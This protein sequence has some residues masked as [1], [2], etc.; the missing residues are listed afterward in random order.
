MATRSFESRAVNLYPWP[1]GESAECDPWC[2]G[3]L[4][5]HYYVHFMQTGE[6]RM[7]DTSAAG[8]PANRGGNLE[9]AAIVTSANGKY[10]AFASNATNL[11]SSVDGVEGSQVYL[12]NLSN[13]KI[14][15]ISET[16]SGS[17]PPGV[18]GI[19][20]PLAISANGNIVLF[21]SDLP[22]DPTHPESFVFIRNRSAHTTAGLTVS[23]SLS[24]NPQQ[25][26]SDGKIYA[27]LEEPAHL[28]LAWELEHLVPQGATELPQV[29]S[30][31]LLS[32]DGSEIFIDSESDLAGDGLGA[33]I[34][35]FGRLAGT[36]SRRT[37]VSG[38]DLQAATR[39]GSAFVGVECP[40]EGCADG[41][42]NI[43]VQAAESLLADHSSRPLHRAG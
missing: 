26:S 13:N 32:K 23:F 38:F 17:T 1:T 7:L 28:T 27:A 30:I 40:P 4:A 33:G 41:G 12:K 31:P 5:D 14:E 42:P 6:T 35:S 21:E 36:F 24:T 37:V 19:G 3:E 29:D 34:F 15:R 8:V 25:L 9:G 18:S 2:P 20:A 43:Y 16:S 10:V 22:L 11:V 39:N